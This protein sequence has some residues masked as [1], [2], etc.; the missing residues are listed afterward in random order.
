M[1]N[2]IIKNKQF[3]LNQ[4]IN[5]SGNQS[6]LNLNQY[7]INNL[8]NV[9]IRNKNDDENQAEKDFASINIISAILTYLCF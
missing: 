6:N 9:L 2:N 5:K 7:N 4:S 3:S 1:K 8:S